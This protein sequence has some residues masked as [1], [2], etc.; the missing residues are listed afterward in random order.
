MIV[1]DVETLSK[2]NNMSDVQ[3]SVFEPFKQQRLLWVMSIDEGTL[4]S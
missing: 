3:V 4:R 2:R 1:V